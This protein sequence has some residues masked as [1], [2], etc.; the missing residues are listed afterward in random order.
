[1]NSALKDAKSKLPLVPLGQ[2]PPRMRVLFITGSHRTG[3]WL[4]DALADDSASEV[5]LEEAMGVANGLARLRDEVY[6]AVLISHS[7]DSLDALNV[8]DAIRAG[9]SDS[10]PIVV[11]GIQSEQEMS[12][13]CYE[14]GGDAYVC[15][16]T[17]TSRTLIWEVARAVERHRLIAENRRL[18]QVQQHRLHLEHDEA[19]RLLGQQRALIDEK[20]SDGHRAGEA[21]VFDPY[22]DERG[23]P[24]L[25][26]PLVSHYREL[27]RTYVIM[28]SGNL[29]D[30]M[31][32]LAEL[33]ASG[34]VTA[35]QTLLLHLQVLEEMI[36]G[37]GNRSA[38][39]V[40]N[41]ADLL[42]LEVMINLAEGYRKRL[43]NR[44]HP[45]RQQLLPGF[46]DVR[47]LFAA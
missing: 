20:V 19:A 46:H 30:E 27:L 32:R 16:N 40:M 4:A 38:R 2:L 31:D 6:D 7:G 18:E 12:A 9:S 15:V 10:Q 22:E 14:A 45:P 44:V 37:L 36:G 1:M 25:P 17:T 29:S 23:C 26:Q 39:H 34:G 3:G 41:R 47:A 28:G 35:Q 13:L 33:L 21:P 8:L 42:I 5:L 11:L 24:D 43:F